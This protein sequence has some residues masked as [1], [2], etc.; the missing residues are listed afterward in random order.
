M[1]LRLE[2]LKE[3]KD[4]LIGGNNVRYISSRTI[5]LEHI[6]NNSYHSGIS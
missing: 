3:N 2:V 4:Y 1:L 6:S 5:A